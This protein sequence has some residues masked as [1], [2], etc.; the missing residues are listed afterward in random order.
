MSN[1]TGCAGAPTTGPCPHC[2]VLLGL[3]GVHVEQVERGPTCLTVTVSTPWELMGC[4]SCGVVAVGRGR[5][6]RRLRDVPGA[7]RVEVRWRQRTWRCPDAGCP[8]GL[9]VEQL[10]RQHATIEGLARRLGTTWKTL[11]RAVRLGVIAS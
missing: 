10:R 9:F 3:D 6:V 5:R 8:V 7:V 2:D 1:A 4:P 11:W